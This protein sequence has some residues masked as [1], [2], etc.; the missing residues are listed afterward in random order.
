MQGPLSG[1]FSHTARVES[2][3]WVL[4]RKVHWAVISPTHWELSLRRIK[5]RSIERWFLPHI[6][7]WVLERKVHWAVTSPTQRE[8]SLNVLNRCFISVFTTSWSGIELWRPFFLV[9]RPL[10]G[11]WQ[12]PGPAWISPLRCWVDEQSTGKDKSKI[13]ATTYQ[14]HHNTRIHKH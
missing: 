7:S 8:L 3:C 12:E 14:R 6:E 1:D 11:R 4:E 9:K 10:A 5:A 13:C 2:K